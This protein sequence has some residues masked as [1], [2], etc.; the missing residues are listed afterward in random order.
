MKRV[1]VIETHLQFTRPLLTRQK[2]DQFTLRW[3]GKIGAELPPNS[4]D[5]DMVNEWHIYDRGWAGIG[6]NYLIK[7]DGAIERG[8]PRR[9]IGAH[10]EGENAHTIGICIVCGPGLPPTEAQLV[11]LYGLLADLCDIYR[12][13]PGD[14]G[15]IKG[16]R[17]DEPPSTPT[18]CPGDVIYELLPI[19][20]ARVGGLCG[21]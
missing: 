19:I 8:R 11:S 7:R 15:T 6:Y 12:L 5:A 13:T 2:T 3:I 14:P 20:R 4:I 9:C 1:D 18:E 16:H 17:D 21:Y 10:D